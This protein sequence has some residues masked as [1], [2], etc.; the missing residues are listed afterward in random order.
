[1]ITRLLTLILFEYQTVTI[2]INMVLTTCK[3]NNFQPHKLLITPLFGVENL[4][5]TNH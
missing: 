5:R 1:M 2:V 4:Y 3:V